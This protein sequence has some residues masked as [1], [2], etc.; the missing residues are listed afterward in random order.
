MQAAA[1]FSLVCF[2]TSSDCLMEPVRGHITRLAMQAAADF[3]LVCF[4]TSSDCLMEPVR[5]HITRGQQPQP[6]MTSISNW[7]T[8][9]EIESIK[10]FFRTIIHGE[11]V[12]YAQFESKM[13]GTDIVTFRE[14]DK[15]FRLFGTNVHVKVSRRFNCRV[16][17]ICVSENIP[18][19]ES[20]PSSDYPCTPL[21]RPN[22]HSTCLH[23][24][25]QEWIQTGMD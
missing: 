15:A 16:N 20:C 19:I 6:A 14:N 10:K 8:K 5:G 7:T 25:P 22:T 2:D 24:M 9:P 18:P 13:D 4:D 3:S 12:D 17:W 11:D 1:D 21:Y 23:D